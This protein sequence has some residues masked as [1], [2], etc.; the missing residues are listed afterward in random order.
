METTIFSLLW[1]LI[2]V[3][4][5][6]WL[7]IGMIISIL[8]QKAWYS[9]KTIQ[10]VHPLVRICWVIFWPVLLIGYLILGLHEQE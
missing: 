2:S 8:I 6:L 4:F 1:F 9:E 5:F 7:G 10:K 3:S